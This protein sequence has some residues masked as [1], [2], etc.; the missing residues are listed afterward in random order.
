MKTYENQKVITTRSSAHNKNN[1]YATI[2]IEALQKAMQTL[3][4]NTFKVWCYMAKNQKNYTYALSCKEVCSFCNI[5]KP[6]YLNC[7]QEL[8]AVGYLVNKCGNQYEFYED[9]AAPTQDIK[10]N[11]A[12]KF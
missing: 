11:I 3:K 1:V 8:I 9:L 2:G 10:A 5:S 4:P 7:I 6:T 12:Y